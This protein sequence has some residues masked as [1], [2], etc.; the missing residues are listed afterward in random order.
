MLWSLRRGTSQKKDL[1]HLGNFQESQREGQGVLYSPTVG[2]AELQG[3]TCCVSVHV[4]M[5]AFVCL[6]P[7]PLT[8]CCY[9]RPPDHLRTRRSCQPHP[10]VGED[11]DSG[12]HQA[13]PTGS[14]WILQGSSCRPWAPPEPGP[15][16]AAPVRQ[17]VSSPILGLGWHSAL[18]PKQVV[19]AGMVN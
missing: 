11:C 2:W 8:S 18:C 7:H 13:P 5:S 4:Y 16:P 12:S 19:A 14:A 3:H 1:F 6:T 10:D 17:A 15:E 9:R